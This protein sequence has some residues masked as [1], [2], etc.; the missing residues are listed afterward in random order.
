RKLKLDEGIPLDVDRLLAI[1]TREL[2]ATQDEFKSVAG[3]LDSGDPVAAWKKAK[4]DHPAPGALARAAQDQLDE[5]MTF[6]DRNG[7]ISRPTSEPVLVAPTP[8]FYRW[9]FA[10]MWVPGPFEQKPGQAYYYV[11]DV[12]PS[13][14]P[15]RQEEH[16][17]DFNYPTLWSIS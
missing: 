5:L 13:W 11:T 7:I 9:S 10:S 8:D 2:K 6:I 16:L 12:D 14:A 3:R 1:A 4:L 15:D 17:R